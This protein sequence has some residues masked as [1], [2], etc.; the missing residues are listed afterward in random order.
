M[1]QALAAVLCD[2]PLPRV[3]RPQPQDED[4]YDTIT[5]GL[6]RDPPS[7]GDAPDGPSPWGAP[8]QAGSPRP[9]PRP[10]DPF[11]HAE[12]SL[13]VG[14]WCPWEEEGGAGWG[15]CWAAGRP[16]GCEG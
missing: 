11:L 12:R 4:P 13:E 8:D 15:G 16:S 1:S 7:L 10:R 9:P 14:P 5:L 3:P 2:T 6:H